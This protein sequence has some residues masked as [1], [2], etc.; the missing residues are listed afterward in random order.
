MFARAAL[1]LPPTAFALAQPQ[2]DPA[3]QSYL[4]HIAAASGALRLHETAEAKRWLDAAPAAHRNWEWRYLRGQAEQSVR[5]FEGH[6]NAVTAVA[7]SPD[8]HRIA[9][10]SHDKTVR[11]WDAACGAALST[12]AGFDTAVLA[13]AFRPDGK[14]LAAAASGHSLRVFDTASGATQLAV[15]GKG[16]GI[17]AVA[18]HPAGGL[19][20]SCSWDFEKGRGV[21]GVIEVRNAVSGDLVKS[22]EF[23]THPITGIAFSPDGATLA[24]GTWEPDGTV[25]LWNTSDWSRPARLV[26]GGEAEYKAVQNIAFSHDGKTLD[27]GYK[28]G[29]ARLWDVA[30]RKVLKTFEGH[31]KWVNGVALSRA[32]GFATV[33]TDQTL[34]LWRLPLGDEVAELH[35]HTKGVNSVAFA[36]GSAL[37]YTA[38]GDG[39]VR[40]WQPDTAA[41]NVFRYEGVAWG[42]A[43]TSD[44]KELIPGGDGGKLR[45]RDLASGEETGAWAAHERT[46]NAIAIHGNRAATTGNDGSVRLWDLDRRE[47]LHTL[48]TVSGI[49][50]TTVAFSADGRWVVAPSQPGSAKVWDVAA[51]SERVR[52]EHVKGVRA[53]AWSPGGRHIATGGSDGSIAVWTPEG[54]RVALPSPHRGAITRLAF[55]PDSGRIAS[56]SGDGTIEVAN[57][58]GSGAVKLS[59]HDDFA[60]G[61]AFHPDGSRIVTASPDQTVRLWDARTGAPVLTIPFGTQA[62]GAFFSRDGETLVTLPMDGTAVLHRI[63]R[64]GL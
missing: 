12:L 16:R 49:Q 50:L 45:V 36:P 62:Y 48:E 8:A 11:I 54:V 15:K 13:L 21:Y 34:R 42:A 47:H 25:A 23:G 52:L 60:Y 6:R 18:Y 9:T 61:I 64:N 56:A 55:S 7:V 63:A 14:H 51:G 29:R 24:A 27:A 43:F 59:G 2:P 31:S 39:T 40:V 53:V 32:G 44:V 41:R 3:F 58:D 4:A 20:A 28:D 57:L 46:V 38:A 5:V 17:A 37:V 19:P 26:P 1:L 33:S 10:A 35:G 22:L 30:G